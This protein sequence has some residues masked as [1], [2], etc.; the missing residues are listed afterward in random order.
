LA[1]AELT[2]A[3]ALLPMG[4]C[5]EQVELLRSAVGHYD[6]LL[7]SVAILPHL[8]QNRAIAI[9]HLALLHHLARRNQDARELM[10]DAV[11]EFERLAESP[12]AGVD[13]LEQLAQAYTVR[14]RI[15]RDLALP[16]AAENDFRRA[17]GIFVEDLIPVDSA[18]A[19]YQRGVATCGRHY[20]VLLERLGHQQEADTEFA[21]ALNLLQAALK[22]DPQ[23]RGARDELALC[24]EYSGDFRRRTQAV[25]PAR[26]A[27]LQALAA[28]QQLPE[29]PEL[30]ARRIRVLL[31]LGGASRLEEAAADAEKLIG[32]H[33]QNAT[34]W[35]LKAHVH[36][37]RRELDACLEALTMAS[38][39]DLTSPGAERLFLLAMALHERKQEGDSKRA[40]E[41]FEQA[42]KQMQEEAPGDVALI[43]LRDQAAARLGLAAGEEAKAPA[44]KE[45]KPEVPKSPAAKSADQDRSNP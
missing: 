28:R 23:N 4:Q 31:K 40:R 17:L 33:P 21:T 38:Q 24:Q 14:G 44:P 37:E 35:T 10:D 5:N 43:E 41:S 34:Y 45:A 39:E 13:E 25:E 1:F 18:D 32:L 26:A 6:E 30:L 9:A 42:A 3:Q 36:F 27:Y 15:L 2:L 7:Q 16:D 29:E 8:R 19:E 11:A 20:A 12:L 22:I